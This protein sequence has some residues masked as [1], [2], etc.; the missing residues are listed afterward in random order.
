MPRLSN[1]VV[2][3]VSGV[4]IGVALCQRFRMQWNVEE[5]QYD[6]LERMLDKYAA[7]LGGRRFLFGGALTAAD[8]S[9]AARVLPL[10]V[11]PFVADQP[12][13]APLLAWAAGLRRDLGQDPTPYFDYEA[14]LL[15]ARAR[16]AGRPLL[17]LAAAPLALALRAVE[18]LGEA[19]HRALGLVPA[20]ARLNRVYKARGGEAVADNDQQP[21][22][23]LGGP[24]GLLYTVATAPYYVGVKMRR[25]LRIRAR[26]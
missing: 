15:E 25:D 13:W 24:L 5:Q 14:Q 9:L 2:R 17:A 7:L 4:L 23:M 12:R 19:A 22:A 3:L 8:L 18:L 20:A 11:V 6:I 10:R 26:P 1:P 21:V 16:S